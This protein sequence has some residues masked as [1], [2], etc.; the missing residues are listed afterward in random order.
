MWE[1]A[2]ASTRLYDFLSDYHHLEL[3]VR[4]RESLHLSRAPTPSS[5]EIDSS[6]DYPTRCIITLLSDISLKQSL[7]LLL[8][9]SP[10]SMVPVAGVDHAFTTVFATEA[11][12]LSPGSPISGSKQLGSTSGGGLGAPST[13]SD[14]AVLTIVIANYWSFSTC[15][16]PLIVRYCLCCPMP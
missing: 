16:W 7:T 8:S 9:T 13:V 4:M 3:L 6:P 14:H 2:I 1:N 10:L 11:Y 15:L 12:T 5:I